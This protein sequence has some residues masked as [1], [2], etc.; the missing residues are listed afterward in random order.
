MSAIERLQE[1]YATQCDDEWEHYYGINISSCDNPGWWVK[2]DLGSTVLAGCQFPEVKIG[3]DEDGHPQASEWLR[4]YVEKNK[5][6]G[7]GDPSQL[8]HIIDTFLEWGG[9]CCK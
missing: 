6:Q 5:W 3:I 7:A 4:C 8:E 1:W 2:I 9:S